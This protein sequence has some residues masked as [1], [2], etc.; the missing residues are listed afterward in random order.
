MKF[1]IS[2]ALL[3]CQLGCVLALPAPQSSE[4]TKDEVDRPRDP[5][6]PPSG[7]AIPKDPLET[8]IVTSVELSFG[9][10]EI[11]FGDRFPA[12]VLETLREQC[13]DGGCVPDKVYEAESF[14]ASTGAAG[15]RKI[16]M[17]VQGS[18]NRPGLPG[19][20]NQMIDAAKAA[21]EGLVDNGASTSHVE[22][23]VVD[24]CPA[25]QVHGCLGSS[26][27]ETTQWKSTNFITVRIN[28]ADHSMISFMSV[29]FSEDANAGFCN[30]ITV[31]GVTA[32][33]MAPPMAIL[34]NGVVVGGILC[35][36]MQ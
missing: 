22:K 31:A 36:N 4:G 12:D 30:L 6:D 5:I 7:V 1:P 20:K 33:T 15:N 17:K 34:G 35:G 11:S 3:S 27:S 23:Y 28:E 8:A 16:K 13:P 14:F 2:L 24:P 29:S 18:F 21:L 32:A 25:W 19:D 10:G 26:I 9:D